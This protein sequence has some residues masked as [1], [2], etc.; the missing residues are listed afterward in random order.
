VRNGEVKIWEE[1]IFEGGREVKLVGRA[2]RRLESRME[3]WLEI[4]MYI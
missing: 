1:I 4:W 2:V 3:K